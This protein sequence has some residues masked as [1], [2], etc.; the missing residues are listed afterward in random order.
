MDV[1]RGLRA[2]REASRNSMRRTD[3][4]INSTLGGAGASEPSDYGF[5]QGRSVRKA[6]GNLVGA[7]VG[8]IGPNIVEPMR[9][10]IQPHFNAAV[11]EVFHLND[12]S[13][14]GMR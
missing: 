5:G 8:E 10:A 13:V 3:D 11:R 4:F 1:R 2:I 12:P 7:I 14:I 6:G 9:E